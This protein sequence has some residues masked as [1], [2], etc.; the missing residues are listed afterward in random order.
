MFMTSKITEGV[1]RGY[2]LRRSYDMD[3]RY[4]FG[5]GTTIPKRWGFA[6][7]N[8]ITTPPPASAKSRVLSIKLQ[9]KYDSLENQRADSGRAGLAWL[10]MSTLHETYDGIEVY[11]PGLDNKLTT[12]FRPIDDDTHQASMTL[13]PNVTASGFICL[14]ETPTRQSLD[15]RSA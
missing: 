15:E 12:Q 7:K 2:V 14:L 10:V 8:S 3:H 6:H 11:G 4:G 1:G 5:M 13:V 9:A